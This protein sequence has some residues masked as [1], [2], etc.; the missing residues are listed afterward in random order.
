[1]KNL[2]C[3]LETGIQ[4]D[5]KEQRILTPKLIWP[6]YANSDNPDNEKDTYYFGGSEALKNNIQ[7]FA[8]VR[9]SKG[10]ALGSREFWDSFAESSDIVFIDKHF[11]VYHYERLYV[12]LRKLSRAVDVKPKN[13]RIYCVEELEKLKQIQNDK[14]EKHNRLYRIFKVTIKNFTDLYYVHDR[15][16]IM[17]QEIWHCGA[18]VGGMSGKLS[19]ISRGWEDKNN[20]LRDFFDNR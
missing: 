20:I 14:Q 7:N 12:E 18:A 2:E 13:I 15:F 10:Y 16:A 8:N 5:E 9:D 6:N 1:M 3:N 4:T 17:D 19:A 11:N